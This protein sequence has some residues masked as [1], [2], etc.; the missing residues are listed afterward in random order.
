VLTL[1]PLG[2]L[3]IAFGLFPGLLLDLFQPPVSELL[4]QLGVPALG[5]R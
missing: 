1:V 5:L 3:T 2:V 4:A